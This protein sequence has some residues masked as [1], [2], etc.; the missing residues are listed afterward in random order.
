MAVKSSPSPGGNAVRSVA[1]TG[2]STVIVSGA[3]AAVGVILAREF[4]RSAETDGFL[5]AYGVYL[6]IVIG[7]QAFRMVVVPELTR[8]AAAGRLADEAGAYLA[9]LLVVAVP[10]SAVAVAAQGPLGEAITGSLPPES[11][12]LA[13]DA[14]AWLVPA[15]LAQVLAAVA[16]SALA[17]R[18]SYGVAALGYAAGAIAG[19][20]LFVA[21]LDRGLIALA[22]GVALNAAI[23]LGLPLTVLV[24]RVGL[25]PGT[26]RLGRRLW[27][28]LQGAATP[29][30]LQVTYLVGLRLAADLDVGDV[31]TLSYA[32]LFAATLVAATASSV[33]LVTS[34]PLT[35]RGLDDASAAH[36]VVDGAWV[37]LVPVAAGAG[38]F[39]LAG[40]RIV[41]GL[42]GNAYSGDVGRELGHLVV[43]LAPWMLVTVAYS[44]TLPLLFV[45]RR[46]GRL[47]PLAA[48]VVVVHVPVAWAGRELLGLPGIALA[49]AVSAAVVVGDMLL[50]ISPRALSLSLV[51]LARAGGVVAAAA[52]AAFG[53]GALAAGGTSGVVL[54]LVL[55]AGILAASASLGLR[56]AWAYLRA[57]R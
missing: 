49:L 53:L 8:A 20:A 26:L 34:A 30:A 52:A 36:H 17:A 12:R 48:A 22:W 43:W 13:G 57:L 9:A 21:L 24:A 39:A 40:E 28:L 4:G 45:V 37:S 41:A 42:L 44:L 7:A 32:Y 55:F 50:A 18:D 29:L 51:G 16:A 23:T 33:S 15:A 6:A 3:A 38:V 35:R 25:R 54:G 19:V 5:A 2:L 46:A 11:A 47:V 10:L 31:T 14:L 1:L 56:Q 27:L